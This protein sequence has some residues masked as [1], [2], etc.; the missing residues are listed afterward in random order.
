M[1]FGSFTVVIGE[2]HYSFDLGFL[3]SL[4]LAVFVVSMF[5]WKKFGEPTEER[6]EDDYITQLLPK[7]LATNEDY[8]RALILY[9]SAMVLV[10]VVL[11]ILG[12]RAISLLTSN[13]VPEASSAVPLFVALLI[14][15]VLPNAPF[16]PQLELMFR[17]FA[18]AR[19]YIPAAARSAAEKL[20][21]ADFNFSAFTK[22]GALDSIWLRGV[23]PN[24]QTCP[25]GSVE[26]NWARLS[27]LIY[28][29]K[30]RDP[31]QLTV[32][33]DGE[34]LR[35]YESDLD[36]VAL[37]R[38]A[39]EDDVEA[40]RR[41]K[42]ANPYVVDEM[43]LK[44]IRQTLYRLYVLLGCAVRLKFSSSADW[45]P[46]LQPFGFLLTPDSISVKNSNIMIV[47]LTVMTV[48]VFVIVYLATVAAA[49]HPVSWHPSQYFPQEAF[50][51]V[52]LAI[53]ALAAQG[54]AIY[55]SDWSRRRRVRKNRQFQIIG[56][57]RRRVIANY[58]RA[59]ILCA[60]VGFIIFF[61][62]GILFEA[63][64]VSLAR[65]TLPFALLPAVTGAFYA[66]HLDNVELKRRPSRFIEIGLQ[67]FITAFFSFVAMQL[68]LSLTGD[69]W[70][71]DTLSL[72]AITGAVIG[73]SLGWYIPQA[74]ENTIDLNTEAQRARVLVLADKA[75]NHFPTEAEAQNWL[76]APHPALG[77]KTPKQAAADLGMFERTL[78]LLQEM[79][80]VGPRGERLSLI[81]ELTARVHDRSKPDDLNYVVK[82]A[83]QRIEETPDDGE[84][85]L[86]AG[87]ALRR[88][89]RLDEAIDLLTNYIDRRDVVEEVDLTLSYAHYN[90]ACYS[91]LLYKVRP[92]AS[93]LTGALTDLDMAFRCSPRKQEL[94]LYACKD[95]DLAALEGDS[96]FKELISKT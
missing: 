34:L 57:V 14:V 81:E 33:F 92:S 55:V 18:H 15:G 86:I 26:Y 21:A 77:G 70:A 6:S 49:F 20:A 91:C 30:Q 95:L 65:K 38:R 19:A 78:G 44:K 37:K 36:S 75:L 48:S 40:F 61:V 9:V 89:D 96:R 82:V 90:R 56:D 47:G 39:L 29:L 72:A 32:T 1:E 35:R 4:L 69:V 10:V 87:R 54:A 88:L 62:W 22:V 8:V 17:R 13:K 12:P 76:S 5:S 23:N 71:Y 50:S 66:L 68:S 28:E 24:D 7:F 31:A 85:V 79:P 73:A 58:I 51:S 16:L 60:V 52:V 25:R 64:S 74:A 3:L 63:P 27:L 93:L 11:S 84:F 53:S 83:K 2:I 45:A 43:L 59:A 94:K 46:A 41:Q 42:A 67:S 80:A